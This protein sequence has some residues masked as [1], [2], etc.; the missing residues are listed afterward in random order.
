MEYGGS[1]AKPQAARLV[2]S[3]ISERFQVAGVI[4]PVRAYL[5]PKLQVHV[6]VEQ[7]F[8]IL[9]G[10]RADLPEHPAL[11]ANN[12]ALVRR[13]FAIDRRVDFG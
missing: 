3:R 12:N 8:D 4:A 6:G 2:L 13:A 1:G 7:G 11:F 9:P 10:G 5:Y